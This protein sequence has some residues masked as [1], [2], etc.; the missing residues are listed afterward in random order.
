MILNKSF[1][2]RILPN[3][4]QLFGSLH[5]LDGPLVLAHVLCDLDLMER[6]QPGAH[7]CSAGS[8]SSK[9]AIVLRGDRCAVLLWN[10]IRS[11]TVAFEAQRV[12]C[13]A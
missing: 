13:S 12:C 5:S 3:I 1:C 4:I 7:F 2:M 8:A 9:S 10:S 11:G 6:E